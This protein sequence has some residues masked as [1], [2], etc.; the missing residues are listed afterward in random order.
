MA[1][2]ERRQVRQ[3]GITKKTDHFLIVQSVVVKKKT[4]GLGAV[5]DGERRQ[6]VTGRHT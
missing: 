6:A 1:D 4:Q 3:T 5:A 2:G